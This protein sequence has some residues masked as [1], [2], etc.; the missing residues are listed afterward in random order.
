MIDFATHPD[1]YRH[2][3]LRVDGPVAELI[4]NVD[5]DG[6]LKPGYALK[7]KKEYA[8]AVAHMAKALE[9][10]GMRVMGVF[11]NAATNAPGSIKPARLV[12]TM[13][14]SGFMRARSSAVT[15]PRVGS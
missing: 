7:L 11:Y 6:G 15:M 13:S 9:D 1:Q 5:E 8:T 4:L 2:W 14:A 10:P 3:T 12:F